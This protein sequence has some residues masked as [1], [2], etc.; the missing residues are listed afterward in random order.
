MAIDKEYGRTGAKRYGGN[1]YEEYL[2]ELRGVRGIQIYQEMSDSD[3]TV[4]AVMFAI[5]NL[6]R[7]APW[8]VQPVGSDKVDIKCAE[9][10]ES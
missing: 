8:S 9:F 6:I 1:F 3:D 10:V 5:K 2:P 7:Q 4:G